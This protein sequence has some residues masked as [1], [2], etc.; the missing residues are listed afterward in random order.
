MNI[1]HTSENTVDIILIIKGTNS[2]LSHNNTRI[3]LLCGFFKNQFHI[4]FEYGLMVNHFVAYNAM[5][6][7]GSE[8][9]IYK[10]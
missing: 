10:G 7:V 1:E 4:G 9:T 5:C 3:V 6:T 8:I 2:I